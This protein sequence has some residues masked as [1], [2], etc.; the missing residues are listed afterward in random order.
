MKSTIYGIKHTEQ[1][2]QIR[3]SIKGGTNGCLLRSAGR[4]QNCKRIYDEGAFWKR[5]TLAG[6]QGDLCLVIGRD[7][8]FC[9]LQSSDRL[10]CPPSL[11]FHGY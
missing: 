1:D 6:Q 9:V 3:L 5:A 4:G 11:L 8:Y 10:S 2:K 7:R